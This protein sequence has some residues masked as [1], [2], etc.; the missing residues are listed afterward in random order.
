MS[1]NTSPFEFVQHVPNAALSRE[2]RSKIRR[3]AMRAVGAAR[4]EQHEA[5]GAETTSSGARRRYPLQSRLL[6]PPVARTPI[7][8]LVQDQGLSPMDLSALTSVH[9]GSRWAQLF[10]L[11]GNNTVILVPNSATHLS[12]RLLSD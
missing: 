9:F 4:R 12:R 8:L 6:Q 1:K 3:H 2:N 10:F 5:D 7:D 11:S